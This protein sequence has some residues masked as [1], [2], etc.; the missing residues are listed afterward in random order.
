MTMETF[1]PVQARFYLLSGHVQGIGFRPFVYRIAHEYGIHGW[2]QNRVGQVAIHAEGDFDSLQAFHYKLLNR[3]PL[4]SHPMV[5]QSQ[6]VDAKNYSS[7][8]ILDSSEDDSDDIR[9]IPD[10]PVCED[11]L[12]EMNELEDRR[13]HY[14]FINC[15]QCGPRYTLIRKL[16][17]DRVNT[18]MADFPMCAECEAE[19]R[20]PLDRRYHAE[21]VAC[22]QC[23]PGLYFQQ[24]DKLVTGN[25]RSLRAAVEGLKSGKTVAVKGL[26]GYH[27]MVDACND[28][29]VELIRRRKPRPH[30][31]LAVM[32]TEHQLEEHVILN[33]EKRVLLESEVHPIVLLEKK[34]G[35][36]LS[37]LIAPQL[38]EVGVMQPYSPLHHLL[39]QEFGGPL[40]ATSANVS[41]EPVLTDNTDVVQRLSKVADAYLHH[42]RAIQRPADDAVYRIIHGKPRILRLGRGNAPLELTLPVSI[43]KPMLAVGGHMKNTIALAWENRI[44]VS[45]HIGE[46]DTLR[47]QKVF[48]QVIQDLQALYHVEPEVLVC[49]AHPQYYTTQYALEQVAQQPALEIQKVF[50]HHAHASCLPAEYP[51]TKRWLV[52]TW[53]GTGYGEDQTIWGGEALLGQAGSWQRVASMRPFHLPGGDKAAREPWRSAAALCWETHTAYQPAIMDLDIAQYAWESKVHCP[54]S[55]S[56]GRMFDAAAALLGLLDKTSFEGQA[57]MWLEALAE[58]GEA[59]GLSLEM[60]RDEKGIW[61]TDWQ[62]LVEVLMDSSIPMQTRARCFHETMALTLLHQAIQIREEHG[63]FS[64]GL[65][66]GVFQNKL[67]TNTV[68]SLLRRHDFQVYMPLRIPVNDGGLCFGQ[69]VEAQLAREFKNQVEETV[70]QA[71]LEGSES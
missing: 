13:F 26:G 24:T 37:S 29:A 31:P 6:V 58:K 19:Y 60:D 16:P 50:H 64:V 41:G 18:T 51:D 33:K 55:T 38:N 63:Y 67:L 10:L 14:P 56:V 12:R 36:S 44:V 4:H 69:V 22:P 46:M 65:S 49:D 40:V 54:Q 9:V 32:M 20:N 61:R 48:E 45:P 47:S 17:Y 42:N 27:L 59:E 5:E 2:V 53:D 35:S 52:F 57:P 11:C 21:P 66:G 30:K 71:V 1:Q 28:E 70:E 3:A 23:G 62:W 43:E 25:E 15:T 34:Q 7:F 68:V 39:L 8:S